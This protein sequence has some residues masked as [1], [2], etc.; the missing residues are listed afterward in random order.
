[1]SSTLPGC[2]SN[3]VSRCVAARP[4]HVVSAM[5]AAFCRAWQR[6]A[7]L[8]ATVVYGDGV[9]WL[10]LVGGVTSAQKMAPPLFDEQKH[11]AT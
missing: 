5:I 3:V 2:P 4:A 9:R 7:R 6:F 8:S 11:G 1:M 10:V